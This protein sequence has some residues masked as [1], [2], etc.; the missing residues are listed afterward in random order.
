MGI[1]DMFETDGLHKRSPPEIQAV[2]G[3]TKIK[4]KVTE[5]K[6]RLQVEMHKI[7]GWIEM[8]GYIY[9]YI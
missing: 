3:G 1:C 6:K 9:I 2:N 4:K 8:T 7:H 5:E